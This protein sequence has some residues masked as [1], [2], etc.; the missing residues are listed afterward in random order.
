MKHEQKRSRKLDPETPAPAGAAPANRQGDPDTFP[1][2]TLSEVDPEAR[3]L[4][5]DSEVRAALSEETYS[6]EVPGRDLRGLADPNQL[7]SEDPY[8]SSAESIRLC[9]LADTLSR[10]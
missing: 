3:S 5:A 1:T 2:I 8:D 6:F 9:A 4:Y 10:K 7:G